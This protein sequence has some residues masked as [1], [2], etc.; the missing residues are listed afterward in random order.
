MATPEIIALNEKI[1]KR[2]RER[3]E[4]A[5]NDRDLRIELTKEIVILRQEKLYL[6]QQQGIFKPISTTLFT[7]LSITC[8]FPIIFDIS[9]FPIQVRPIRQ[10]RSD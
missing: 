6:L 7:I 5:T 4:V 3:D 10:V 2:E 1:D 8:F 9:S